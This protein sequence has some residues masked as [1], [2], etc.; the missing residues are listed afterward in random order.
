MRDHSRHPLKLPSTNLYRMPIRVAVYFPGHLRNLAE[1]WP[2]YKRV[3]QNTEAITFD[4]YFTL[5]RRNHIAHSDSWAHNNNQGKI[6]VDEH[7]ITEDEVKAICPEAHVSILME[8]EQPP[9]HA[10]YPLH[11]ASQFYILEAAF[12][13]TPP[14]YDYY[15][16]ARTDLYFF[17]PIDWT[18]LFAKKTEEQFLLIPDSVHY[19]G[20]NW[21]KG[22]FF[23]DFFWVTDRITGSYIADVY[24]AMLTQEPTSAAER[25]YAIHL[26]RRPNPIEVIQT[27]FDLALERRTRGFDDHLP[28]T[29][30]YTARRQTEGDFK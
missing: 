28:E 5:W 25:Y 12:K 22:S 19:T 21:P 4:F 1:N 7:D 29:G 14:N 18:G 13:A 8:Y 17:T 16:R 9:S 26:D 6:L 24:N 3:F 15:V 10:L 2:N 20:Y 11:I 23:N 27:R 30:P